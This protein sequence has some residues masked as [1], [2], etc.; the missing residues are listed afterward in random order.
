VTSRA[1]SCSSRDAAGA[2]GLRVGVWVLPNDLA[3]E[4]STSAND[5]YI[6]PSLLSQATVFEYM[7]RGAFEPHLEELTGKLKA[8]RDTMVAALERHLPDVSFG[9]PDGGIFLQLKL[10][11]GTDAKQAVAPRRR[12]HGAPRRR[13]RRVPAHARPR[14]RAR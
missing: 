2:P 4:L 9:R 5:T 6:T 8:R 10:A 3:A 11:P 13:L 12:R 7:R 1:R 14:R